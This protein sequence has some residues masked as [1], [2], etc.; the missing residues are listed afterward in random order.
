MQAVHR[1]TVGHR[2]AR[3]HQRLADEL[4]AWR[5]RACER[6]ER[7]GSA[8]P[9]RLRAA[10]VPDER[11]V[12]VRRK[13]AARTCPRAGCGRERRRCCAPSR[14]FWQ[15]T[16]EDGGCACAGVSNPTSSRSQLR[17]GRRTRRHSADIQRL[18]LQ[19]ARQSAQRAWRALCRQLRGRDSLR[20]IAV[21]RRC[22]HDEAPWRAWRANPSVVRHAPYGGHAPSRTSETMEGR[23][24][25]RVAGW[26]RLT[27]RTRPE[28]VGSPH[29]PLAPRR[30]RFDFTRRGDGSVFVSERAL[31]SGWRDACAGAGDCSLHGER[32]VSLRLQDGQGCSCARRGRGAQGQGC[33]WQ[34][35]R[36]QGD[37]GRA[38]AGCAQA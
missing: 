26:P 16:R 17:H 30:S 2:A 19:D 28:P 21:A 24:A 22:R 4:R 5:M 8:V 23:P 11:R 15:A 34:E 20:G 35:R 9:R 32:V 27:P 13:H 29:Q 18:Q 25:P 33:V 36:S 12:P 14:L 1:Q 31:A 6:S 10:R 3:S 38:R 37:G 7:T